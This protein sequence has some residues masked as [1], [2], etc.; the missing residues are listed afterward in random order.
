MLVQREEERLLLKALR[1]VSLDH[2][3]II[4]T[5]T[6]N[7]NGGYSLDDTAWVQVFMRIGARRGRRQ[8]ES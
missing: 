1:R 7:A 2:Q 6:P 3:T 8:L 4:E 5:T